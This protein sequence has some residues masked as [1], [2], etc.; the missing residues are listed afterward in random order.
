MEIIATSEDFPGKIEQIYTKSNHVVI[1]ESY[2]PYNQGTDWSDDWTPEDALNAKLAARRYTII[3]TKDQTIVSS[4]NA[5]AF[6]EAVKKL[7]GYWY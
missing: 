6:A 4:D 7:P 2:L 5:E 3:N 1:V